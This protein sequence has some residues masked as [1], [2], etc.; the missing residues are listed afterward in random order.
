[1]SGSRLFDPVQLGP[2]RLR[3]RVVMAPMTRQFS[4]GG[5]P[6]AEVGDYYVRRAEGGVG[7][8]ISEGL[9]IAHPASV[10]SAAIPDLHSEAALAAWA[11]IAA[12]VQAAGAAFVPQLWHVG[13]YRALVADRPR[14]DVPALSPSGLYRPG[15]RIGA[16][17]GDGDIA[18]V[19][20]AY[21]R[22]AAAAQAIGCDGVELHGAHGYL[23]DQF[24]WAAT[25]RRTDGYNGDVEARSRFAAEVV[26]ACRAAT[27]PDFPLFLRFSQ[28]K[29]QDYGA[30][31]F[32]TPDELGR[33]LAVMAEAG[34]DVFDC[35]TRRF[36]TPEFDGSDRTLAGWTRRLSGRP[37]M[38]VGSV[39][40][41]SD[42][43]AS[44]H[45]R[46]QHSGVGRL[47]ELDRMLA[48]GE[49][50]LVGVGRAL[51]ADPAWVHKVRRGALEELIGFDRAQLEVLT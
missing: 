51:L 23:I 22:A 45:G 25:N 20:E 29:T 50:D 28:W 2:L 4:P 16:P 43:V 11:G 40:L 44:L 5:V 47:D 21:A 34:V 49:F 13:G 17:A 33:F 24:L 39:G 37:T 26:A 48:R 9:E 19:V 18:A 27:S 41:D 38:T 36:W 46:E 12:R 7:L 14:P 15:E 35:S 42:V 3:N 8:I 1:M 6:T 32:S 10:H 31:L 30:R